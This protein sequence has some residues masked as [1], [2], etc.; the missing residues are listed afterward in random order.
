MIKSC[1]VQ[2]VPCKRGVDEEFTTSWTHHTGYRCRALVRWYVGVGRHRLVGRSSTSEH[3]MR[4]VGPRHDHVD[5]TVKT[6]SNVIDI[7]FQVVIK[8]VRRISAHGIDDSALNVF[9]PAGR[10]YT[11]SVNS[12]S[13]KRRSDTLPMIEIVK[14]NP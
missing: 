8:G 6:I 5:F 4:R 1:F 7:Y 11:H 2:R 10:G 9:P 3:G 13:G 14:S 12:V